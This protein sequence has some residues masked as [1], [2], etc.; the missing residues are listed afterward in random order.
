MS[1]NN[2]PRLLAEMVAATARA[3]GF[4]LKPEYETLPVLDALE[5]EIVSWLNDCWEPMTVEE[6][7]ARRRRRSRGR[8]E[9][10]E[11]FEAFRARLAG[12]RALNEINE[13]SLHKPG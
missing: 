4:K 9:E 10:P 1:T 8:P 2:L 6:M 12:A 13:G 11:S 5:D 7:L 3:E